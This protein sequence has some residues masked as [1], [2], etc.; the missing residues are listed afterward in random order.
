MFKSGQTAP[1]V[2]AGEYFRL[3]LHTYSYSAR[4][5]KIFRDDPLQFDWLGA[6]GEHL[7]LGAPLDAAERV[8]GLGAIFAENSGCK[9]AERVSCCRLAAIDR[10]AGEL[11]GE[12]LQLLAYSRRVKESFSFSHL[13]IHTERL[14]D[15]PLS[16]RLYSQSLHE[17]EMLACQCSYGGV[18][19]YASWF[20]GDVEGV[21]PTLRYSAT[22]E[23]TLEMRLN[24]YLRHVQSPLIASVRE[25]IY[26]EM[27]QIARYY[28]ES[29]L[30]EEA[31]SGSNRALSMEKELIY[32]REE[33]KGYCLQT[34]RHLAN[35][36]QAIEAISSLHPE[37]KRLFVATKLMVRMIDLSNLPFDKWGE[38]QFVLALLDRLLGV[39]S[40][41]TSAPAGGGALY[42][43]LARASLMASFLGEEL[44][45][46]AE[47]V[48]HWSKYCRALHRHT[49]KSG[50]E[51]PQDRRLLLA[52]MLRDWIYRA[53]TIFDS[54]AW[55]GS[56]ERLRGEYLSL[57]PPFIRS[58]EG[59]MRQ[60][61]A[62]DRDSLNVKGFFM[63]GSGEIW[64]C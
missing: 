18:M 9:G 55:L 56:R 17:L 1:A 52:Y 27:E 7:L 45:E 14:N 53:A 64:C 10:E 29:P 62:I 30:A 35:I 6:E 16:S 31:S 40:V 46:L 60:L 20:G 49:L 57:F 36:S 2:V 13:A 63:E 43:F 3:A 61:L 51:L 21:I 50:F 47:V 44:L 12:E 11:I 33:L 38:K 8:E 37:L 58:P 39:R 41:I 15:P 34:R 25:D 4:E 54:E 32:L 23:Y 48:L 42:A 5:K 59:V 28:G 19:S 22:E 26:R 24:E